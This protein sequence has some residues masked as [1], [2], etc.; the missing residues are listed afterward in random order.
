MWWR[1]FFR[2]FRY[3]AAGIGQAVCTQRNLRV[4]LCAAVFAHWLGMLAGLSAGELAVISLC[5]GVVISLELVNTAVEAVCDRVSR[6][7]HPLIKLAKD[8]AA[9]A[10]LIAAGFSVLAAVWLFGGWVV[11]GGLWAV[12]AGRPLADAALAAALLGAFFFVRWDGKV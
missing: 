9:G 7:Y 6:E 11:S 3:A 8:A 2:S 5:C 12:I 1:A 4:H 10:V